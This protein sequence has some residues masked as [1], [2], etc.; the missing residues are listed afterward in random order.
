MTVT[1]LAFL[2]S[3]R[4]RRPQARR[5]RTRRERR[6]RHRAGSAARPDNRARHTGRTLPRCVAESRADLVGPGYVAWR[7]PGGPLNGRARR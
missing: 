5:G 7:A 6:S 1:R 3:T 4:L 2:A